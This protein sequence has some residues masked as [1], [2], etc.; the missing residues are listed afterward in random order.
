[1]TV[2]YG[3]VTIPEITLQS[4]E[5]LKD[6]VQVYAMYGEPN[7]ERDNVIV[8]CHALTGSHR[9]AGEKSE[10]LPD[11]WWNTIVG[12][13]KALD[14]KKYCIFCIDNITSPYGSTS[15]LSIN[16]NT[17]K[18]YAMDFPIISPRDVAVAQKKALEQI[19]FKKINCV[20]G[21][22]LGGMI[23]TEIALTY[24]DDV[25]KC[26]LIAAPDHLYP[27]AIAFNSVQRQTIT[28]DPE[29]KNGNYNGAGPVNGLA[30][31]RM[32]AMITYRSEQ[33]FSD[34]YMRRT[35][36]ESPTKW[37]S[38]FQVEDYLLYHG[39]ELVRRFDANCYLYLTKM[40]DL[41][42]IGTGR[43]GIENAWSNFKGKKL[44]AVGI[45]SDMLFPN[46]QVEEAVRQA[47]LAGVNAK[48]DEIES[49]NGHDSFLIDFDQLDDYIRS[50]L[51]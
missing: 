5:I 19:G 11:P 37:A 38:K 43:G 6:I 35:D 42:D 8:V 47:T 22:S 48:Y 31:A 45:S 17:G 36:G 9:L 21:P 51:W 3:S 2:K 28:T 30:A 15:P 1:M 20:I 41:H 13:N 40:M 26:V 25:E 27:Q 39:Q 4:G 24:P 16:P 33:S 49:E 7:V 44:L 12:D 23:A 46:W 34:R 50:F 29:W 10:G 14:T 18:K 32:L